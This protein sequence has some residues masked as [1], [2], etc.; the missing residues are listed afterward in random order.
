M[1]T[2]TRSGLFRKTV[3]NTTVRTMFI[4][5][6]RTPNPQSM[7]FIP[8]EVV[9]PESYGTGM[10]FERTNMKE[11]N[12]SPLAKKVFSIN[13]VKGVFLGRD[14]ITVTKDNNESWVP[15]R[16]MVY[17]AILDFY[18]EG[19]PVVEENPLVSDTTVLEG[20]SEIIATIKELVE[21]RVRPSVQ[22]DGGDIFYEGFDEVT[23]ALMLLI[24]YIGAIIT[25]LFDNDE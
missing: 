12:R 10:F 18:A 23:G 22:E 2:S 17:S 19:K 8:D 4:N 16:P 24:V 11:V 7:K 14:F 5:T 6:E 25:C 15:L 3:I 13:G 20:D 21:T 1:L 9:L